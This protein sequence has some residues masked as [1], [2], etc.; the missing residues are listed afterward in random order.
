VLFYPSRTRDTL[1]GYKP[2]H[3]ERLVGRAMLNPL[4]PVRHFDPRA[5][6]I[7]DSG[8][9]QDLGARPRL[10]PRA[11][12]D[13]QL[14]Y[15]EQL[16]WRTGDHDFHFEAVCIYDEMAGVDE[17]I[18]EGR[19]RKVR[20][21]EDTARRAVDAT[22]EAAAYYA[23]RRDDVRGRLCFVGQGINPRQY[24][25]ECVAPM[26][27][28]MRPDDWFAFG[29]FCI[30]G[31]QRSLIPV[32]KETFP[33][34]LDALIPH[35]VLR[36]HLL[37]VCVPEAVTF[38]SEAAAERGVALSTDSSAIELASVI[39]GAVYVNG[40]KKAGP[41]TKAQKGIDYCPTDLAHKNIVAY[42]EWA[43]GLGAN[44]AA[45]RCPCG[46]EWDAADPDISLAVRAGVC[47]VCTAPLQREPRQCAA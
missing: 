36:F 42:N 15:E 7:C 10:S 37:G 8:A 23:A 30:I 13:R 33:A 3:F 21:N 2:V 32:F 40:R 18:V 6:A 24:V 17:A 47:P 20:G 22:L 35:G 43:Y 27:S 34:A 5:A 4:Y 41:W 31:R 46:A 29:G 16:R 1:N 9:F 26:A 12:M 28:L 11:A 14:R 45:P 25:E 39:S 38:A 44:E 19:K